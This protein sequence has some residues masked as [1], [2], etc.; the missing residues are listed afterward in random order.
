MRSRRPCYVDAIA[1]G[2]DALAG[3]RPHD[4]DAVPEG[5]LLDCP[6]ALSDRVNLSDKP[7]VV[8]RRS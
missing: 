8:S 5:D 1:A 3:E 4:G 6:A 7:R 2:N